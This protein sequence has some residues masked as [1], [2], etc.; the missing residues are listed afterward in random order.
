ME[1]N[2]LKEDLY[3]LYFSGN[4]NMEI[5]PPHIIKHQEEQLALEYTIKTLFE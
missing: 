2:K 3:K 4:I 5:I 1:E